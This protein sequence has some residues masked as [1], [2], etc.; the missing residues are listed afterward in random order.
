[1]S[2][3]INSLLG[4]ERPLQLSHHPQQQQMLHPSPLHS[5]APKRS[6]QQQAAA[7]NPAQSLPNNLHNIITV[8]TQGL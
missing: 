1:M 3:E 6:K 7:M 4:D 5:P 8:S 2:P